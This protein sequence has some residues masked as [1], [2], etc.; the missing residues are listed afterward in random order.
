MENQSQ[1]TQT[2]HFLLRYR[3]NYQTDDGRLLEVSRLMHPEAFK[4]VDGDDEEEIREPV[5]SRAKTQITSFPIIR[6]FN[7]KPA[8]VRW[9]N[10]DPG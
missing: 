10:Y 5:S 8:Y 1:N 2:T 7:I 9:Q 4:E 3:P 6:R